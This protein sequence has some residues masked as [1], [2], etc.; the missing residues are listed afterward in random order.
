MNMEPLTMSVDQ[1]MHAAAHEARGGDAPALT[2]AG[3][4]KTLKPW[5]LAA[6]AGIAAC[7]IA[8]WTW[9]WQIMFSAALLIA[10]T[11]G[12]LCRWWTRHQE[13]CPLDHVLASYTAGLFPLA[14][15]VMTT[16]LLGSMLAVLITTPITMLF[17]TAKLWRAGQVLESA[18]RWTAFCFIEEIWLVA[19]LR[20]ARRRRKHRFV[21]GSARAQR[22]FALYATASAIGYATAQCVVL[23]CVVAG[24]M[25]GHTVFEHG[26]APEGTVTASETGGLLLLS[27][28]FA[29]FLLPL[30]LVASHLNALDLERAPDDPD[31]SCGLC[32]PLAKSAAPPPGP[33]G[34]P[35]EEAAPTGLLIKA[36]LAHMYDVV[37]WPW[38]L[39]AAHT[40]QFTA[41]F[42]LL[43]VPAKRRA[44]PER[45]GRP[46]SWPRSTARTIHAAPPR[47]GRDPAPRTIHAAPP[48]RVRAA[49]TF[50]PPR[51]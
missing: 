16:A 20:V 3:Q 8:L 28:C 6:L 32:L 39:R 7:L 4:L 27:L 24:A 47:R 43:A 12:P 50:G 41:F 10:L 18:I 15:V 31:G 45:S 29:W 30:R 42:W 1:Q 17:W 22:A 34:L 21:E 2:V 19:A 23:A 51:R 37:K 44:V 9:H 13:A 11:M 40:V 48:R 38:A 25:E 35:L 33:D 14:I 36:R 5:T 46:M 49:R 26:R